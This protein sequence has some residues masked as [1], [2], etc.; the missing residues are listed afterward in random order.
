MSSPAFV[1]IA[2]RPPAENFAQAFQEG[3]ANAARNQLVGAQTALAQQ[4]L[5]QNSQLLPPKLQHQQALAQEQQMRVQQ[6]QQAQRDSN[7]QAA[8]MQSILRDREAD[9]P[10]ASSAPQGTTPAPD[11]PTKDADE[12]EDTAAPAAPAAPA[13]PAQPSGSS[14]VHPTVTQAAPGLATMLDSDD[15]Y[16]R[17]LALSAKNGMSPAGQL[18]MAQGH[19][20]PQAGA[21]EIHRGTNQDEEGAERPD[22]RTLRCV[23]EAAG[24]LQG[25]ALG[26]PSRRPYPRWPDV[27]KGTEGRDLAIPELSRGPGV[28]LSRYR[29]SR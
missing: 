3:R 29:A 17:V 16:G 12:S 1:A 8:A 14:L 13:T 6:I 24:R 22:R 20:R 18:K 27:A 21:G 9:T 19:P 15:I 4:Q 28:D 11:A 25:T 7:I 26:R 2:P 23:R 5:Q 10:D